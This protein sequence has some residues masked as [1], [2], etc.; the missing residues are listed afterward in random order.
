MIRY[1]IPKPHRLRIEYE[2]LRDALLGRLLGIVTTEQGLMTV[3]VADAMIA[4]ARSR[5]TV[6]IERPL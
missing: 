3:A 2:N 5:L 6:S 4:S 1:A